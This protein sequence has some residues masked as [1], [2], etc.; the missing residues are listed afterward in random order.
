MAC[1]CLH[2]RD[3]FEI[4]CHVSE[5]RNNVCVTRK[6]KKLCVFAWYA[7]CFLFYCEK[8]TTFILKIPAIQG[9]PERTG[10]YN[11]I[12][13]EPYDLNVQN[14][15]VT[16]RRCCSTFE[17]GLT[18]DPAAGKSPTLRSSRTNAQRRSRRRD[19][20]SP[21]K[22][23]DHL[24]PS[25]LETPMPPPRGLRQTPPAQYLMNHTPPPEETSVR[26]RGSQRTKSPPS[27]V[28]AAASLTA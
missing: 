11:Q 25:S 1:V 26:R 2:E 5:P 13:R 7:V 14:E 6:K 4:V 24:T 8:G 9:S 18:L 23:D 10:N 19:G 28:A 15:P 22:K 3:I 16:H 27:A 20:L 12:P 17:A 21:L